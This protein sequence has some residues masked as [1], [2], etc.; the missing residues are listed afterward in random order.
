MMVI[1]QYR[2][3]SAKVAGRGI[4]EILAKNQSSSLAF[5]TQQ[6]LFL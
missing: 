2:G 6:S 4:S 1:M 3:H 5:L